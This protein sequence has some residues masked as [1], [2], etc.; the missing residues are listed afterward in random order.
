MG[1]RGIYRYYMLYIEFLRWSID[2]WMWGYDSIQ[3]GLTTYQNIT[4]DNM[5]I[6]KQVTKWNIG[7]TTYDEYND[8]GCKQKKRPQI[9][10]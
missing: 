6:S 7:L 10:S 1:Y 4:K 8:M 3:W 9:L 5:G 2:Q